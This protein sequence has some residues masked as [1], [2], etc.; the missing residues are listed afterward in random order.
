MFTAKDRGYDIDLY[1]STDRRWIAGVCGGIAE[2]MQWSAT[3]VRI[4]AIL[5]FMFTGAFAVLAYIA[6]VFLLSSRPYESSKTYQSSKE[7]GNTYEGGFSRQTHHQHKPNLKQK[8]FDYGA[9]ASSRIEEIRTRIAKV[10]K[11]IRAMEEHVTSR[12]FHFD[13]EMRRS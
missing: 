3:G 8:M 10:D 2:N 13:R 11:R 1:R 4:G 7:R 12:K 5:L 9:S 6:A